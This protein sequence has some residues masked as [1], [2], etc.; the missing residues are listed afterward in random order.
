MLRASTRETLTAH[1]SDI[2]TIFADALG[3]HLG[4][5]AE[6]IREEGLL[7]GDFRTDESVE[8]TLPDGSTMNLRYAF[9]VVDPEQRIAGVF[10]EHCGYYCFGLADTVI[11]HLRDDE[12]VARY[13][14]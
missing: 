2:R 6:S 3:E 11:E 1:L 7:V 10:S 12:V 9:V 5:S 14:G 4:R 13:A 8:L